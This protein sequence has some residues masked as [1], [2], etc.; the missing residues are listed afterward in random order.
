[1]AGLDPANH[2][3]DGSGRNKN[4]HGSR[5]A[6]RMDGRGKPCHDELEVAGAP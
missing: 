4:I 5:N 3:D 1:M 2:R 6:R